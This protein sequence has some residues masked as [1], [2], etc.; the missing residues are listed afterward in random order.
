M[1][2]K[3]LVSLERAVV[4][5]SEFLKSEKAI[6]VPEDL[7][8]RRL[9][10]G[11]RGRCVMIGKQESCAIWIEPAVRVKGASNLVAAVQTDTGY[12]VGVP[13]WQ[14]QNEL[15]AGI[16]TDVLPDWRL[17]LRPVWLLRHPESRNDSDVR[18]L[19]YYFEEC[20]AK[21]SGLL[22]CRSDSHSL[23]IGFEDM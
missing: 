19:I 20:W 9:I 23:A 21:T 3:Q 4:A 17:A 7:E 1:I 22:S 11:R 5:S 12:A 14:I 10:A 18:S 8:G 2:A 13:L 15:K 6:R 16:L